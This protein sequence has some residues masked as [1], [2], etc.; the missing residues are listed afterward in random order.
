VT[1]LAETP[2]AGRLFSRPA[3][4]ASCV[5][6]ILIGALQA[7]YGPAIPAIRHDHHL[8]PAL[9]GLGAEPAMPAAGC[10]RD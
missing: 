2:T 6:F 3:V 9:A 4:A 7:L 8:S 10:Y 5:G 1:T